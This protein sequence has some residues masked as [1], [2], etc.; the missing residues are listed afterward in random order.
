MRRQDIL[1]ETFSLI[2]RALFILVLAAVIAV[3]V[4]LVLLLALAAYV[5]G[6]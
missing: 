2:R 6:S 3:P 1:T 5:G 4:A